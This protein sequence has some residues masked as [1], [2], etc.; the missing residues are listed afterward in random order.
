MKQLT[1]TLFAMFII[2]SCLTSDNA[3]SSKLVQ[4]SKLTYGRAS[5]RSEDSE[6]VPLFSRSIAAFKVQRS[7][8][9]SSMS[10]SGY[11]ATTQMPKYLEPPNWMAK[12]SK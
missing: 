2:V 1:K 11:G 12:A 3:S 5:S 9:R 4:S 7:A 6:Q 8:L 10:S